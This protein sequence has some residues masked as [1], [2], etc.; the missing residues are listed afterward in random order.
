M[1]LATIAGLMMIGSGAAHAM[2]N[3]LLKSGDDKM[4]SRALID[5]FSALITLPGV[6]LLPLP[7]HA[8]IWLATSGAILLVYLISLIK[9]FESADMLVAYPLMRGLAPM[10]AS[11]VAVGLLHDRGQDGADQ[12]GRDRSGGRSGGCRPAHRV[13]VPADREPGRSRCR[14]R[15]GNDRSA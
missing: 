9:A 15:A 5:G 10:L 14:P 12:P 13:R 3:A 1:N 11:A 2:V 6:F 7:T 8:W 4:S